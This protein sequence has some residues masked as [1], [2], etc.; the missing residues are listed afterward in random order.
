MARRF[1]G[2]GSGPGIP[3][4]P[5]DDPQQTGDAVADNAL[6]DASRY[7]FFGK[8]DAE[9]GCLEDDEGHNASFIRID[10]EYHFP[11][12]KDREEVGHSGVQ[13]VNEVVGLGYLSDGDDLAS[14]FAKL[15]RVVSGP[16][17]AGVIGDRGSFSRESSSTA[18]WTQ[19]EDYL[20]WI[21]QQILD[22]ENIQE[23]KRWWSQPRP[24]SSQHSLSKPL[25]RASS[26][27]QQPHYQQ[28]FQ[29]QQ[30]QGRQQYSQDSIL[31]SSSIFTSYDSHGGPSQ[32]PSNLTRHL[33]IPSLDTGFQLP[34]L[35]LAPYSDPQQH[36][37]RLG[38]SSHYGHDVAHNI[39][40][41][42][43]TSGWTRDYLLNHT[44]LFS[45]GNVSPNRL[46][47]QLS[48]PSNLIAS[49]I[50]TQHQQ[51]RLPQFQP[52]HLRFSHLQANLFDPHCSPSHMR[53]KFDLAIPMPD[54]RDNRHRASQKARQHIR[55]SHGSSDTGSSKGDNKWPQIRSKYMAPEE[56]E[57]ILKMQN[58]ASHNNDPY[59]T[60]YYHQACLAKKSTGRPKNN[61]Y[62]RSIK[63]LLSRSRGSNE[64]HAS[65]QI[66]AAGKVP[67]SSVRRPSPL[68]EVDML[69]RYA[70][71]LCEQKSSTKSLEQEP[72]VA[73]RITIED[74]IYLLL[75]VDDIDRLLQY[76]PP[77]D[78]GS[79]LRRRRQVSL[80]G[81]AASLNLVDPLRPGGSGYSGLGPK[82]DI[83]FLRI[84]SLAKG[85]KLISRYLQLLNPGSDLT[86]IVCMAIFRHL[87]FLFG[88][89]SSDSSSSET[90]KILAKTVSFCVHNME[91]SALSACLAAIV[92]ST[93]QPPLRP[94]G[95]ASGD[96]AT[97][98]IKSVLDRATHLLTDPHAA[99]SYSISKRTLWQASFDAFFGLLTEYCLSKYDSILQMLLGGAS[100]NAVLGSEA[101]IAIRREMPVDL[102]RASLPHTSEHQ[103]KVL[104]DFAQKLMPV[105][106]FSEHGSIS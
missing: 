93:E 104:I 44:G 24:S 22:A 66:D 37:G 55:F 60:D 34:G 21:D 97:I 32:S 78:G 61:F 31:S 106:S 12:I 71:G 46:Q 2:E 65:L 85:Q 52:S 1:E 49:Q 99:G 36:S 54:L 39:V 62:P 69:P 89:L 5:Y 86:R 4:R 105:T 38:H 42:P 67:F 64:S 13:D 17:S 33:S 84:V 91:L 77:Q 50:L 11:I 53:N 81:L 70:D 102:L 41:S 57:S 103:R 14:T 88:G 29:Q 27:P 73:A 80:D 100:N 82:D 92:C 79:Q 16:R 8:E 76:N 26:Y 43:T 94:I 15:N 23:G 47:Q 58:A 68:L 40:P 19:D 95:S 3:R 28:P 98:V 45:S 87:R 30:Q 48:L 72:L 9:L 20:N 83:V 51:H 101:T 75:D 6:F 90:V 18:D 96:G 35:T 25:Y 59:I 74:G 7:A 63:D 56:I 10:D